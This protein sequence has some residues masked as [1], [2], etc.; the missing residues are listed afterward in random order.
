MTVLKF[1]LHLSFG[2]LLFLQVTG[3]MVRKGY[4]NATE[5]LDGVCEMFLISQGKR[6]DVNR[7]VKLIAQRGFY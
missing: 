4:N 6:E 3:C 7:A 5:A 2:V 1:V